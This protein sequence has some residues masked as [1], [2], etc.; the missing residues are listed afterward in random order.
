MAKVTG[1]GGVFFKSKGDSAALAAWYQ[2]HLGLALDGFG[3]T[4]AHLRPVAAPGR[5]RSRGLQGG[6]A[7][8]PCCGIPYP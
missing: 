5:R 2:T 4:D 6:V 8:S 1:I 3:R 7:A